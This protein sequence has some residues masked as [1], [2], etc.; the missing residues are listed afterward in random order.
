[1]ED[2]VSELIRALDDKGRGADDGG[3]L[4]E[5]AGLIP[6]RTGTETRDLLNSPELR[7]FRRE[8]HAGKVE[9]YLIDEALAIL[10]QLLAARG[11]I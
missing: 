5:A 6:E 4:A 9:A 10:R 7:N 1:M 3:E 8:Y 11:L 2:P